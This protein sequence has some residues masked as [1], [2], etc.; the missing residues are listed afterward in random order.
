MT[1]QAVAY[2]LFVFVS[3]S[4]ARIYGIPGLGLVFNLLVPIYL[5][6]GGEKRCKDRKD[7]DP[8]RYLRVQCAVIISSL[9]LAGR[10][11]LILVEPE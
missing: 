4:A 8:D 2:S 6:T 11:R 9:Y 3:W 10:R 7:S 5:Y 1:R